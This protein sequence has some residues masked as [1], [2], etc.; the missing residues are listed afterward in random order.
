[1]DTEVAPAYSII[2]MVGPISILVANF[3]L[4]YG[5]SQNIIQLDHC[6]VLMRWGFLFVNIEIIILFHSWLSI[7]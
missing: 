7:K 5:F 6:L 2:L 1:M 3:D 4:A